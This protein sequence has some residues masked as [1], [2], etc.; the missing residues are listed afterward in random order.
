MA[1]L[2]EGSTSGAGFTLLRRG[3]VIVGGYENCYRP[4]EVFKN[5]TPLHTKDL[6]AN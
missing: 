3:R 2:E 6:L 4:E 5:Q 1:L